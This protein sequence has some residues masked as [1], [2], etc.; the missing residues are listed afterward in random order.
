MRNRRTSRGRP[1][2]LSHGETIYFRHAWR[3]PRVSIV[4]IARKLD[5]TPTAVRRAAENLFLGSK[6]ARV[7]S[8]PPPPKG[9]PEGVKEAWPPGVRFEDYKPA[10]D[11]GRKVFI[12][13]PGRWK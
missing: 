1:Y 3:D 13:V 7:P 6:A 2:V 11:V 9:L 8:T 5:L 10:M 12:R 4:K